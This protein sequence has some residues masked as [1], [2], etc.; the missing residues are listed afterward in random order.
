M[1]VGNTVRFAAWANGVEASQAY[2]SAELA[3]ETVGLLD[4]SG[5]RVRA[6][7]GGQRQRL[8]LAASLAHDPSV[9]LL[10]EPTVGLDPEQRAR[11][12]SYLRTASVGRTVLVATHLLEDISQ[13]CD[14]VVVLV[15]GAPTFKGTPVDLAQLGGGPEDL[16]E[17][18]LERGYRLLLEEAAFRRATHGRRT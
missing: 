9:L 15:D 12:R 3:L 16:L 1:T 13:A 14:E 6:L 17:S 4:R 7:S 8:G 5:D 10:D 18:P 2:A 11:F